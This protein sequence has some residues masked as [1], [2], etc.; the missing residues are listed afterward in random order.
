VAKVSGRTLVQAL[1]GLEEGIYSEYIDEL[2]TVTVLPE[3]VAMEYAGMIKEKPVL[4][5]YFIISEKKDYDCTFE[6]CN[7]DECKDI[8]LTRKAE[9]KHDLTSKYA[10]V[11]MAFND[12]ELAKVKNAKRVKITVK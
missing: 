7:D 10:S 2:N 12:D 6:F 11:S 4:T 9:I 5:S 1:D 8:T 3:G